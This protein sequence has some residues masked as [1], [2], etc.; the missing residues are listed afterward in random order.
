MLFTNN[1]FTPMEMVKINM[2]RTMLAINFYKE[3]SRNFSETEKN[4]LY[5]FIF[6]MITEKTAPEYI[7]EYKDLN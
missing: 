2:D 5:D 4:D 7:I 6:D 3:C 1:L